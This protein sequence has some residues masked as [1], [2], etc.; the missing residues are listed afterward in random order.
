MIKDGLVGLLKKAIELKTNQSSVPFT[1][2]GNGKQVRDLLHVSDCV[3]LYLQA[4][5]KVESI[6]GQVFNI[7]GGMKN[8]FSILEF[9]NFVENELDVKWFT[10]NY[11]KEFSRS[12]SFCCRYYKS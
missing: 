11:L 12:K 6:K 8:S 2:S 1:I 5:L 10:L 9:F 4:S 7:G 3:E